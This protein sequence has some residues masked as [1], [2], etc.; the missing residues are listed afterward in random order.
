MKE[1][2]FLLLV[3]HLQSG[4]LESGT[5][6]KP[7]PTTRDGETQPSHSDFTSPSPEIHSLKNLMASPVSTSSEIQTA[8]ASTPGEH[9]VKITPASTVEVQRLKTLPGTQEKKTSTST[10]QSSGNS[11]HDHATAKQGAL[12]NSTGS[13]PRSIPRKMPLQQEVARSQQRTGNRS[14]RMSYYNSVSTSTKKDADFKKSSFETT[15]G[16]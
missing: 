6:G 14:P 10:M 11:S 4:S 15:R 16:K 7:W 1:I 8:A 9:A 12:S 3:S 5:T 2:I 13:F